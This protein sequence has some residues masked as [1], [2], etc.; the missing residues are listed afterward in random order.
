MRTVNLEKIEKIKRRRAIACMAVVRMDDCGFLGDDV[1]Y[2]LATSFGFSYFNIRETNPGQF[3]IFSMV[4]A[5]G[6]VGVVEHFTAASNKQIVTV[7]I[8]GAFCV[9]E[10]H[11]P[12]F[13]LRWPKYGEKIAHAK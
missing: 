8:S 7:S 2:R 11:N 3:S 4:S 13:F 12:P 1:F 6:N 5:G 9:L 10:Y